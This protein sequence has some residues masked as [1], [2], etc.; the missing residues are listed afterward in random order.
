MNGAGCHQNG[1][2]GSQFLVRAKALHG[3]LL[4]FLQRG[5]LMARLDLHRTG[6]ANMLPQHSPVAKRVAARDGR[7][8]SVLAPVAA[9]AA[10]LRAEQARIE[11]RLRELKEAVQAGQADRK[12]PAISAQR[13]RLLYSPT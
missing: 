1:G 8:G 2:Y 11:Q 12:L 10:E 6:W 4:T 13:W 9:W 3:T 7:A 5:S